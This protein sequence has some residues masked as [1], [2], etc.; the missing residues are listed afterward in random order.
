MARYIGLDLHAVSCTVAVISQAGRQLKDL[1]VKT[2]A[3]SLVEAVRM[4]P[5]ESRPVSRS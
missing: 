2:N 3:R 4:I 1:P 5:G